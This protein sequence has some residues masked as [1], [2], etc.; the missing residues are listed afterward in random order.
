MHTAPESTTLRGTSQPFELRLTMPCDDR[1]ADT[2]QALVIF[3]AETTGSSHADAAALGQ[4]A[5]R[6]VSD[7]SVAHSHATC[8]PV[9][10]RRRTG[11]LE[12]TVAERVLPLGA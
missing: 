7:F 9:V 11:A 10:L 2:L 3:A 1:F 12:V 4:R 5:V 8:V 6:A